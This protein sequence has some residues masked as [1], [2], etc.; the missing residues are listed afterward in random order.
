LRYAPHTKLN[1]RFII[2]LCVGQTYSEARRVRR[3]WER[4]PEETAKLEA[5]GGW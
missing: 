4:M 2:R 3:A 5:R 1:G